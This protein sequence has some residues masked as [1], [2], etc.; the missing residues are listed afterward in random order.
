MAPEQGGEFLIVDKAYL[1]LIL[2]NEI[3]ETDQEK[4]NKGQ[5]LRT[6]T[7]AIRANQL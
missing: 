5:P 2:S 7:G 4:E 1:K 3:S 6:G